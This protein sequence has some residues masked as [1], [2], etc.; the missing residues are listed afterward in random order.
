M[1]SRTGVFLLLAVLLTFGLLAGEAQAYRLC[2]PGT[3]WSKRYRVC[4]ANRHPRPHRV[5]PAGFHWSRHYR[6]CVQNR[7]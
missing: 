5:C 1:P 7:Y 6:V 2:P 3:H 4:V